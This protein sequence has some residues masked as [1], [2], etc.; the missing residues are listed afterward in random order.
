[1]R[2]EGPA[3]APK[4]PRTCLPA[5]CGSRSVPCTMCARELCWPCPPPAFRPSS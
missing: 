1:L 3:T 5:G 2:S 4:A